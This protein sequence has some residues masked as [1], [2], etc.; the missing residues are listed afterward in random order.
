[1]CGI[2]N[3]KAR[4]VGERKYRSGGE[5]GALGTFQRGCHVFKEEFPILQYASTPG[6]YLIPFSRFCILL[7]NQ[8]EMVGYGALEFGAS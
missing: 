2:A 8:S 7:G 5:S 4:W 3:G 6:L 1:M